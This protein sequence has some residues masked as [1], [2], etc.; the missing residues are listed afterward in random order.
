[1]RGRK[2]IGK[3]CLVLQTGVTPRDRWWEPPQHCFGAAQVHAW[4]PGRKEDTEGWLQPEPQ[5]RESWMSQYLHVLTTK[6]K[7]VRVIGEWDMSKNTSAWQG[8]SVLHHPFPT[9]GQDPF[10][11]P[12]PPTS[13][14]I[15]SYSWASQ[16]FP[17]LC[18]AVLQSHLYLY[19]AMCWHQ[20]GMVGLDLLHNQEGR[21]R[22]GSAA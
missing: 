22:V 14:G 13:L 15:R 21:N 2:A 20:A 17:N 5:F 6:C 9:R 3:V 1:M 11:S 12:K 8:C 10:C 4:A 18:K 16:T 7:N 19:R